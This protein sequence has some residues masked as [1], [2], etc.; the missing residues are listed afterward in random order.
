MLRWL[1]PVLCFF[2][3]VTIPLQ[4]RYLRFLRKLAPRLSDISVPIPGYFDPNLYLYVSDLAIIA[5]VGLCLLYRTGPL[6]RM[7]WEGS[8]KF[9]MLFLGCALLSILTSP[10]AHFYLPY[11]RLLQFSLFVLLFCVVAQ[12]V[13]F[14]E[15]RRFLQWTCACVLIIALFECVVGAWQFVT[16]STVGLTR[17]GEVQL[18][19]IAASRIPVPSEGMGSL[20]ESVFPGR[21]HSGFLRAY[22]TV[23][24]PNI[25]GGFFLFSLLLTYFFFVTLA[26]RSARILVGVA[27]GV[28]FLGMA[29][30]FS[31][32][33]LLAL[34]LSTL[35]WFLL[36]LMSRCS[37][38]EKQRV[39]QLGLAILCGVGLCLVICG[40][41]LFHRMNLFNISQLLTSEWARLKLQ[42]IANHMIHDSPW[43]GIGFNH[44]IVLMQ[45]HWSERL[46]VTEFLPVHNIYLFLTAEVGLLGGAAFGLFL[47]SLI[48]GMRKIT[49]SSA[50][51]LSILVGLLFIGVCDYYLLFFQQGKLLFFLTAALLAYERR[52]GAPF[53]AHVP[54]VSH[55]ELAGRG[56]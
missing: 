39:K 52:V 36:T 26:R 29:L 22:G 12:G 38:L 44:F 37:D 54:S 48:G 53:P 2:L 45:Q 8:A 50:T 21:F 46:D 32:S 15:Y 10:V 3:I 20:L 28:Q 40:K 55:M 43:T 18:E 33:A 6:R 24:H 25:L 4:G 56:V 17:L 13:G 42:A 41:P 27:I 35:L 1:P 11:V 23:P 5:L 16:N 30:T 9:L 7:F 34:G 19:F 49:L 31:R 51:F 14:G 47:L